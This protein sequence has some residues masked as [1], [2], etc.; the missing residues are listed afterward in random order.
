MHLLRTRQKLR[1]FEAKKDP[2]RG[3]FSG[4]IVTGR[5]F[6]R[7]HGFEIGQLSNL[8]SM[9]ESRHVVGRRST[10]LALMC[11]RAS[12]QVQLRGARRFVELGPRSAG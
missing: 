8:L 12:T 7:P 9:D 2:V 6:W 5:T 3:K 1:S 4:P 11:G 10:G